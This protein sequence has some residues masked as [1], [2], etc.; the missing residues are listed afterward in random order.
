MIT[1]KQIET[2]QNIDISENFVNLGPNV[3]FFVQY[4]PNWSNIQLRDENNNSYPLT[5]P[6]AAY[7]DPYIKI[8]DNMLSLRPEFTGQILL[9]YLSTE[10]KTAF[11]E[12]KPT[13]LYIAHDDGMNGVMDPGAIHIE[14]NIYKWDWD[15]EAYVLQGDFQ[16]FTTGQVTL[17]PG[18]GP[19][20]V[21]D[22][23]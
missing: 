23:F 18:S 11:N 16:T 5:E 4:R 2:L 9:G 10:G 17:R 6:P 15:E 22:D 12:N 14:N 1:S 20:V 3:Q 13:T 19:F 21:R 7:D 8:T